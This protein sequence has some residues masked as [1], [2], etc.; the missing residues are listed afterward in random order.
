[1]IDVALRYNMILS[2]NGS[3]PGGL[4]GHGQL[5]AGLVRAGAGAY[6]VVP[7]GAGCGGSKQTHLVPSGDVWAL[8]AQK[9]A[10]GRATEETPGYRMLGPQGEH[11]AIQNFQHLIS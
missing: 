7:R 10:I 3:N 9:T 6:G 1:M 5:E 4:F 11:G 8:E 2:Q